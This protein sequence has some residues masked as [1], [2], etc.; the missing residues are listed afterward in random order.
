MAAIAPDLALPPELLWALVLLGGAVL[1]YAL[2]PSVDRWRALALLVLCAASGGSLAGE[3]LGSSVARGEGAGGL[4]SAGLLLA[5]FGGW[6]ALF[7]LPSAWLGRWMVPVP[8]SAALGRLCVALGAALALP[9]AVLLLRASVWSAVWAYRR[10]LSELEPSMCGMLAM[11]Q[12]F[13]FTIVYPP[14]VGLVGLC[15]GAGGAAAE[16]CSSSSSAELTAPPN[17]SIAPAAKPP[18]PTMVVM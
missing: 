9:V 2:A 18:P 5:L 3:G 16:T 14:V 6:N 8:R 4:W 12:L 11:A 15:W 1:G 7:A 13:A 17:T 10:E